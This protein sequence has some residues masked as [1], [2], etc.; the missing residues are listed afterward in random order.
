MKAGRQTPFCG[1]QPSLRRP[2]KAARK[3]ALAKIEASAL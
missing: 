2:Q 1:P 3:R